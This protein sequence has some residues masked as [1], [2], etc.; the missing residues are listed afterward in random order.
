MKLYCYLQNLVEDNVEIQKILAQIGQT[1]EKL[2]GI[3]QEEGGGEGGIVVRDC[4]QL[5]NYLLQGNFPNQNHFKIN[6]LFAQLPPLLT[7]QSSDIWFLTEDKQEILILTLEL[8]STLL[9]PLHEEPQNLVSTQNLI[10][11]LNI[12]QPVMFLA[13]SRLDNPAVRSQALLTLSDCIRGNDASRTFFAKAS[14]STRTDSDDHTSIPEMALQRVITIILNSRNLTERLGAMYVFQSYLFDNPEGQSGIASTFI[15]PPTEE[16]EERSKSIGRQLIS[17]FLTRSPSFSSLGNG[18][19][20]SSSSSSGANP[21]L[22]LPPAEV[23]TAWFALDC[24][25]SV[26]KNNI[27]CKQMVVGMPLEFPRD[28]TVNYQDTTL[29]NR[30]CERIKESDSFGDEKD[31]SSGSKYTLVKVGTLRLLCY[32]LYQAPTIIK[33]FRSDSSNIPFLIQAINNTSSLVISVH[34]R[35][36]CALIL[37]ICLCFQE[38]DKEDP[39]RTTSEANTQTRAALHQLIVQQITV[40]KYISIL[41]AV[42]KTDS[43]IFAEQD[44]PLVST[45]TRIEL[46]KGNKDLIE[47]EILNKLYYDYEFVTLYKDVYEKTIRLVRAPFERKRAGITRPTQW[48]SMPDIRKPGNNS[49]TSGF[50]EDEDGINKDE[51]INNYKDLIQKQDADSNN[52]RKELKEIKERI[53]AFEEKEEK[54]KKDDEE[55]KKDNWEE[56]YN[57]L[58]NEFDVQVKKIKELEEVKDAFTN[59]SQAY[60]E[61]EIYSHRKDEEVLALKQRIGAGVAPIGGIGAAMTVAGV[62]GGGG[63]SAEERKELQDLRLKNKELEKHVQEMKVMVEA[64]DTAW[65]EERLDTLEKELLEEREKL[66]KVSADLRDEKT[67]F[68]TLETEQDEL[69]V[70]LARVELEKVNLEEKL[71]NVN[72]P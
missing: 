35:A 19:S 38:E 41:D 18:N 58:R 55:M 54:R 21:L 16:S 9:S 60:N 22:S 44:K 66:Q 65:L 30:V 4:L 24:L 52:L 20:T 8:I 10:F 14:I 23:I 67:R 13:L 31:T 61:L 28:S 62:G 12:L 37:G 25:S 7:L 6:N 47:F 11:K 26:I 5:M 53:K 64:N 48:P 42:R 68:Q 32:W 43:F 56:K 70:C 36:L 34:E 15:P 45:E 17:A 1:F 27:K 59:L 2:F 71:K 63:M 3:I 29:F 49:G 46:S 33:A 72:H 39:F 40:D 57:R 69:L 51:V 50:G